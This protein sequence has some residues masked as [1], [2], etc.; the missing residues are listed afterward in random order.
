KTTDFKAVFDYEKS[1]RGLDYM[2]HYFH[3]Y[4]GKTVN[5]Y[6]LGTALL[7]L[8]FYLLAMLY[9]KMAFLPLDGYNIIFQYAVGLAAAFYLALG[10]LLTNALLK[11]FNITKPLRLLVL[12]SLMLGTNLF[13]YAFLHPAH[14]HVYSFAAIAAL[15]YFVRLF[16]L[17][18]RKKHLFVAAF[19]FGIVGLIRPTNLILLILIPFFASDFPQFRLRLTALF[20]KPL[21]LLWAVLCFLLSFGLQPLFNF[22]QTGDLILYT[23]KNEGFHFFDPAAFLFLFSY[24]KGFFLYTPLMLLVFSGLMVL[25]RQSKYQFYGF[26]G[27]FVLLV[28][29]LS[30]WWNWFFGDSF[31]MRSMIDY[32]AILAVLLGLGFSSLLS[33]KTGKI[34]LS[35]FLILVVPLNLVQAYQY[36][37]GILH[38]DSMTK[39]KYWYVFLKT[40]KSYEQ[41]LGGQPEPIFKSLKEYNRLDYFMDME[42]ASPVWTSNGIKLSGESFSGMYLAELDESNPFSPTLVLSGNQI[43]NSEA[44]AGQNYLSVNLIYR[45]L[46]QNAA[47]R[48]MVVYAATNRNNQL[49]F[50]KVQKLK[51]LPD[52][53][54]NRWRYGTY[55]FKIP[56]WNNEVAQVKVYVWNP[57][58]KLFQLDDLAV[59]IF[60]SSELDN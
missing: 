26:L 52:E 4:K 36:E 9:S 7:I 39:E 8:P 47:S 17:G 32:Y 44:V 43:V 1:Q 20:A 35:L 12:L 5:K 2:G 16:M 22:I 51:Q 59:S 23:Y 56:A 6:Y 25:Y 60:Y 48:A 49:I 21:T 19:L 37:R 45:E 11:T 29:V 55:G 58:S 38:P 50:Y 41:I 54:T 40:A 34:F 15:A 31:G 53:I 24:Q 18:G 13:Y 30:S 27:F 46:E 14:S 33:I 3:E 42:T 10:L 28:Y 57:E